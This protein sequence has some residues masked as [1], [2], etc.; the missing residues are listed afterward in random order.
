MSK[1]TTTSDAALKEQWDNASKKQEKVHHLQT[2]ATYEMVGTIYDWIQ[3]E[4]AKLKELGGKRSLIIGAILVAATWFCSNYVSYHHGATHAKQV[5]INHMA[6]Q[7]D[8]FINQQQINRQIA[9]SHTHNFNEIIQGLTDQVMLLNDQNDQLVDENT[10]LK[11]NK[12]RHTNVMM[13]TRAFA[14]DSE[15]NWQLV[16]IEELPEWLLAYVMRENRP[17]STKYLMDFY[18]GNNVAK[19]N[20]NTNKP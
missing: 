12:K 6:E 9:L 2:E 17:V 4:K 7:R 3:S 1:D 16:N 8:G 5:E 15:R 18:C 11:K 20:T 14:T 13:A 19:S 10:R